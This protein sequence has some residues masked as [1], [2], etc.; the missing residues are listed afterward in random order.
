MN[1]PFASP[2]LETSGVAWQSLTPESNICRNAGKSQ[3]GAS[4]NPEAGG[5]GSTF[6]ANRLGNPASAS[7][8]NCG[9]ESKKIATPFEGHRATKASAIICRVEGRDWWL[10]IAECIP[11][12]FAMSMVASSSPQNVTLGGTED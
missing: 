9:P 10:R 6:P 8:R 7:T 1:A 3:P 5:I 12:T 4:R 2:E 11:V